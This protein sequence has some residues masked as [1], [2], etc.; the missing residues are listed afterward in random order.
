MICCRHPCSSPRFIQAWADFFNRDNV[1][2]NIITLISESV[3]LFCRPDTSAT[4][5]GIY[6]KYRVIIQSSFKRLHELLTE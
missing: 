3:N 4:L 1:I 6:K 5:D 2:D